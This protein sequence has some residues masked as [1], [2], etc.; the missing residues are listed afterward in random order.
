MVVLQIK[1]S[2]CIQS[3]LSGDLLIDPVWEATFRLEKMGFHVL[4]VTCDG[5]ST[6]RQLWKLHS[7]EIIV[8]L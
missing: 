6:N 8:K 4:A 1:L 7:W 5:V 2:L 3:N